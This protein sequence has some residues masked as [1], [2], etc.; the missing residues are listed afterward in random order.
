VA[1]WYVGRYDENTYPAFK[2]LI[3]EDIAWCKS[4]KID[5]APLAFPGFSWRNMNGPQAK[6]IARNRG[7]FFWKQVVAA[8][9]AGAEMLYIAMFDEMNEGTAI[10]KCN[11]NDKLP[12]NGSGQFTGIDHDLGS[13]YYLWLAGQAA[14]WFHG[15]N[16]YNGELPSRTK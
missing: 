7:S 9:T 11:T 3:S 6:T 13:D 12:L 15:N 16:G 14:R 4:N 10:F 5:Y 2:G 1:P 8:K